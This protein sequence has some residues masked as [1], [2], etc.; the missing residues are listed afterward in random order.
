MKPLE[1]LSALPQ[2][3]GAAPGAILDS[4]AFSMPC[5]LGDQ[6]AVLRNAEIAPAAS[7]ALALAVS[8]ADEPHTLR[9]A[10]SPAFPELDKIWDSRSDVPAP[11]LLALVEKECGPLLQLLENAVRR[12]LRLVGL[13]E[14]RSTAEAEAQ[15]DGEAD[16]PQAA[17]SLG[18]SAASSED[19]IAFSLTR[20]AT[21]VS[22][23]GSL[24]NL[25]L[26]HESIRSIALSASVEYASFALS[27]SDLSALAVGDAVL[28]PEIGGVPARLIA[29][30]RF[31]V[32]DGGVA[33]FS[34]DGR[35]R[36][37]AAEPRLV[38][39]GD[40]FDA[41]EGGMSAVEGLKVE[42]PAGESCLPLHLV[43]GGRTLASGRLG[44]L[45]DHPAF[46]VE[47]TTP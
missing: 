45:A 30:G 14:G 36:V 41:A 2:W 44:R 10:R 25:E 47:A 21:V 46:F 42:T 33:P 19:A 7:E 3:A 39:L 4:P 29:D 43:Q 16:A 11:I 15:G 5:R 35:C 23:L 18:V 26:A 28:L 31:V 24:R 20:S 17:V 9:I 13:D 6:P 34:D 27:E 38:T 1:I 37:L 32:D 8:F 40:L 12:Q 22:A